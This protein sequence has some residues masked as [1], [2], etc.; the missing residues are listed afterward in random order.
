MSIG[1][2]LKSAREA[3]G[4]DLDV[5]CRVTK[6]QRK[7]LEAI[8]SDAYEGLLEPAYIKIFL[9]N[10]AAY[11]G[12]DGSSL[13]EEYLM[14][15]GGIP[16][17]SLS[18]ETEVTRAQTQVPAV[19]KVLVPAGVGLAALIG[20]AFL[21][22]LAMDLHKTLI[23]QPGAPK[24]VVASA[25]MTQDA[26]KL[27]IPKA[28]PLKLTVD[29]G[30]DVWMQIKSDGAVIFQNTLSK[31]SRESWVAKRELEIWTGNAKA[32]KLT[33][34]GKSLGSLGRG[35][36]KGVKITHSGLIYPE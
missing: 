24:V 35:V 16:E 18:L 17:P 19:R 8:E 29:A 7:V 34:N 26:P 20:L 21:G 14:T 36:K 12:L 22:F 32:T 23:D 10:Y 25:K 1:N 30:D 31:G 13:V 5:A 4:I 28:K 6:I 11:L 2:R 33:L 9:K 27:L 15:S 3:K